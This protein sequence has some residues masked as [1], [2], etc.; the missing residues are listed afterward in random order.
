MQRYFSD[1]YV[2]TPPHRSRAWLRLFRWVAPAYRYLALGVRRLELRGVHLLRD[3]A[4][5]GA[6]VILAPNHGG[7]TDGPLVGAL[8]LRAGVYCYYL[9]AQ[10]IFRQ[11]RLRPWL[12]HRLGC[13][14]ILREGTDRES[15]RASVHILTVAER[16]LVV[17]PEGTWYRQNDRVGP[18]QQGVA[19]IAR[20]AARQTDRPIVIHPVAVKYWLLEDPRPALVHRLAALERHLECPP[21][22]PQEIVGRI[23]RVTAAWLARLERTHLGHELTGDPEQRRLKLLAKLLDGLDET[24]FGR[25]FDRPTMDRVWRLRGLFVQRLSAGADVAEAAT[26]RTRLDALLDCEF[27]FSHSLS[28]LH[29][30]PSWERIAETTQRLAEMVWD[31]YEG[32]AVPMGAVVEAG[33][34]IAMSAQGEAAS[35]RTDRRELLTVC[36]AEQIQGMLDRLAAEGPPRS[37]NIRRAAD[38]ATNAF[39][40]VAAERGPGAK[41]RDERGRDRPG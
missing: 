17:F 11:G 1:P 30:K 5:S 4:G 8:G 33:P 36:V 15:L 29:E 2:F 22:R 37:W 18:V 35:D 32:P 12:I 13:F 41:R 16:P 19:L 39:S 25:V 28:Y 20:M 38:W 14:S 26:A 10:H 24:E 3:S 6:G 31:R 34:A 40:P 7:L 21:R 27:L 23:E 9:V